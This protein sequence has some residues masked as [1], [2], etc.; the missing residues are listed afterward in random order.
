MYVTPMHI[1]LIQPLSAMTS[2]L[3]LLIVRHRLEQEE[4]IE[5]EV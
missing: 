2:L 1:A 5:G 3:V 4:E